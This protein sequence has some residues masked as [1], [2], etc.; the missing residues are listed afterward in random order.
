MVYKELELMEKK[1]ISI[2]KCAS[3]LRAL[4][5]IPENRK[6][7][8]VQKEKGK[9]SFCSEDGNKFFIYKGE[10]DREELVLLLND[11]FKDKML[12]V[13]YGLEISPVVFIYHSFEIK[14]M[15]EE[16]EKMTN[17]LKDIHGN[18]Y[19]YDMNTENGNRIIIAED[20]PGNMG[21]GIKPINAKACLLS[22]ENTDTIIWLTEKELI[23]IKEFIDNIIK[24]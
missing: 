8:D 20:L 19:G 18:I 23:N 7:S 12:E 10:I 16:G 22:H 4:F 24:K 1:V 11:Y 14:K 5:G 21:A 17:E 6:W 9:L 2:E 15:T 3:D 13:G